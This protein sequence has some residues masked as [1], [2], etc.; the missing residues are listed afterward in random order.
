MKG[1]CVFRSKPWTKFSRK[2]MRSPEEGCG[3]NMFNMSSS[4]LVKWKMKLTTMFF[5]FCC[6]TNVKKFSNGL[7]V[8]GNILTW[9]CTVSRSISN[10]Q[11]IDPDGRRGITTFWVF[12]FKSRF[13]KDSQLIVQQNMRFSP[14]C[15]RV[16]DIW[17]PKAAVKITLCL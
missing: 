5:C 4:D 7:L 8:V 14:Q 12:I 1:K 17:W 13:L 3:Q 15:S 10:L 2:P 6:L 11:S 9:V 16:D